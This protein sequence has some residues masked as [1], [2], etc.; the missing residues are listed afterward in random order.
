MVTRAEMARVLALCARFDGRIVDDLTVEAWRNLLKVV[1]LED[2]MSA[3]ETH[4]LNNRSWLMPADI[5][6][7]HQQ[8]E[9]ARQIEAA[10]SSPPACRGCGVAY[11]L[12][13]EDTTRMWALPAGPH[14]QGC[15][16]MQ[17]VLRFDGEEGYWAISPVD[18]GTFVLPPPPPP[19][20]PGRNP[21]RI[22][23]AP[24]V[25][26]DGLTIYDDEPQ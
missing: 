3:V 24:V 6:S 8:M 21:L 9:A 4:Y 25:G 17:G 7:H 12:H 15:R 11:V 1:P 10:R 20:R 22:D 14:D 13:P 23:G 26:D 18:P 5:F 16:A 19:L 2:L